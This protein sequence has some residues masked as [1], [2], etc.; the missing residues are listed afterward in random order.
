MELHGCA[1][2]GDLRGFAIVGDT[3]WE[4]RGDGDGYVDYHGARF[5]AAFSP[6]TIWPAAAAM[7]AAGGVLRLAR[8]AGAA[9]GLQSSISP[10]AAW[11]CRDSR[12]PRR[13]ALHV[14]LRR[15]RYAAAAD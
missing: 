3:G 6:A 1:A 14:L 9:V 12:T 7:V 8:R 2:P 11:P 4:K 15:L 13:L 10:A 5:L